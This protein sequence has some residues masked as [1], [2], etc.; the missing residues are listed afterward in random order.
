M[1]LVI[2]VRTVSLVSETIGSPL[3]VT[4]EWFLT[5][6]V[7]FFFGLDSVVSTFRGRC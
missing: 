4:A 3:P 7:N 1:V 2:N 5:D 6:T